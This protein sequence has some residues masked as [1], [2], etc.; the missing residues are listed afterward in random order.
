M[1]DKYLTQISEEILFLFSGISI[2][3]HQTEIKT[4]FCN[5]YS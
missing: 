5:F 1:R 4:T 3:F 2:F